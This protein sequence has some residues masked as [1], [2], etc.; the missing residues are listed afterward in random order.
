MKTKSKYE[1]DPFWNLTGSN[2]SK[3]KDD[4]NHQFP[5]TKFL[6]NKQQKAEKLILGPG[7]GAGFGCGAGIGLGLLG[8][9]GY[10]GGWPPWN[11]LQPVFGVGMGCGVGIGFGF[12]QG[13]GY[14]FDLESR[15][16]RKSKQN[17]SDSNKRIVFQL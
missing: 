10:S 8:G 13:I 6:G 5:I 7:F 12:G 4:E 14:S 1:A 15:K 16:S 2:G 11:H 3:K 9:L 17:F